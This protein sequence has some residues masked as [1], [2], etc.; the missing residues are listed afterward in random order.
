MELRMRFNKE[1]IVLLVTK[2]I[3]YGINAVLIAL[4]IGIVVGGI[5]LL[6]QAIIS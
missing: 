5:W 4:G 2:M 6:W 1:D 3:S